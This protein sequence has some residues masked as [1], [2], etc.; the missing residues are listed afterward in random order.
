MAT[1]S[2]CKNFKCPAHQHKVSTFSDFSLLTRTRPGAR[3]DSS[4]T[5]N[6]HSFLPSSPRLP[7]HLRAWARVLS[8]PFFFLSSRSCFPSELLFL[9]WLSSSPRS[10][11]LRTLMK[12]NLPHSTALGMPEAPCLVTFTTWFPGHGYFGSTCQGLMGL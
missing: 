9:D 8:F 2:S 5:D 1:C 7:L 4:H 10:I 3:W 11:D 12:W 6:T